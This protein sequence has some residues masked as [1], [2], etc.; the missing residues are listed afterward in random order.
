MLSVFD[1]CDIITLKVKNMN[2]RIVNVIGAGLAGSEASYQLALQEDLKN[3][4]EMRPKKMT[5]VMR[6]DFLE[7][8]AQLPRAMA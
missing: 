6:P 2:N 1:I 8:S 7:S 5:T 3:L 4:Y